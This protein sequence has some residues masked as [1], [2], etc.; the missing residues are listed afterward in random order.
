MFIVQK[1]L[2]KYKNNSSKYLNY[3]QMLSYFYE[4]H[5]LLSFKQND[6]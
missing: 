1:K 6:C 3:Y 2:K 4:Q 5:T